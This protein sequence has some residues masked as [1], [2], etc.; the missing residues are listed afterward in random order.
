MYC[1]FE[2]L[3]STYLQNGVD[4]RRVSDLSQIECGASHRLETGLTLVEQGPV[5]G[6]KDNQ[7]ALIRI[8]LVPLDL[9]FEITAPL[10]S[11][12]VMYV[13]RSFCIDAR[14]LDEALPFK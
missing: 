2:L 10:A 9:S 5:S 11:D 3:I 8:C 7:V 14:H 12:H 1:I 6:S 4:L 13:L